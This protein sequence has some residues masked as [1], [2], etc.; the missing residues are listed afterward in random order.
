MER[1][2]NMPS[3]PTIESGMIHHLISP[4]GKMDPLL[5]A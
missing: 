3:K 4:W 1:E 2:E 5:Q